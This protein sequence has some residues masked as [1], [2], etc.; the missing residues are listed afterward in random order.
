MP[1]LGR[2]QADEDLQEELRLHLE[3]ERERRRKDRLL[4]RADGVTL[5]LLWEEYAQVHPH[6]YRRTQF[7][8]IYGQWARRLRP[9]MRQ[10]HRT[11]AGQ[12]AVLVTADTRGLC[13]SRSPMTTGAASVLRYAYRWVTERR[14][15]CRPT[16]AGS[17]AVFRVNY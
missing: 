8:E 5:Q 15:S 2:R 10:V 3:L 1:Y 4:P 14:T 9:S 12:R 16:L 7:C 13:G 11:G 6:G 17:S